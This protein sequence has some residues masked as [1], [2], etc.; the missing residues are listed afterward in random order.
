MRGFFVSFLPPPRTGMFHSRVLVGALSQWLR[1]GV[2]A[3]HATRGSGSLLQSMLCQ[4][5]PSSLPSFFCTLS[6]IFLFHQLVWCEVF[7]FRT[8]TPCAMFFL[9]PRCCERE[10][11]SHSGCITSPCSPLLGCSGSRAGCCRRCWRFWD[12]VF[13]LLSAHGCRCIGAS[14]P[15]V[16]RGPLA[17][18]VLPIIAVDLA[19]PGGRTHGGEVSI[20]LGGD[21]GFQPFVFWC[22]MA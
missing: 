22:F 13:M 16:H 1:D 17:H 3:R 7:S 6:C 4:I 12:G 10:V 18:D 14:R 8:I 2:Y 11:F 15:C 19:L 9:F 21:R 20:E 5:R